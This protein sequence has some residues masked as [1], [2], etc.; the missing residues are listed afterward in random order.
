LANPT[1]TRRRSF[2]SL[3]CRSE[4][5][6]LGRAVFPF[7]LLDALIATLQLRHFI[8]Q[9]IA[10]GDNVSK[11]RPMLAFQTLEQREPLFHLLQPCR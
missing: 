7:E 8:P 9:R 4:K 2:D 1:A 5:R 6:R 3:P 11:R 10:F